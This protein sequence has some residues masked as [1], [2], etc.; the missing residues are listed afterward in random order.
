MK[1]VLK[2]IAFLLALAGVAVGLAYLEEKYGARYIEVYS[3][4]DDDE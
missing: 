1:T 2:V 4:D 3:N